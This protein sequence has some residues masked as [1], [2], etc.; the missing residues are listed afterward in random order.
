MRSLLVVV[1][2]VVASGCAQAGTAECVRM[3][4]AITAC[5][6]DTNHADCTATCES[7]RDRYAVAGCGAERDAVVGCLA[8]RIAATCAGGC[9]AESTAA[10]E[11]LTARE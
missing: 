9:S 3:C 8:D 4:D 11:C 6:P 7:A 2:L 5:E 10:D 1:L